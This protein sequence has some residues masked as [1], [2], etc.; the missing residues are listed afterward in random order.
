MNQYTEKEF[1]DN[2]WIEEKREEYDF[3]FEDLLNRY[4]DWDK[5]H[6]YMEIGGAPGSIMLFMNKK[7]ELSVSTIDFTEKNRISRNLDIHGVKDYKIYHEDF[8][9]TDIRAHHG[10]YDIVASWGFLEHFSRKQTSIFIDKQMAMVGE[11]GYFIIELPN[12]R[13]V[14]WLIYW[15]FNRKMIKIHNL[16][17]MDLEWL[18]SQV[19]R[20]HN[21]EILYASY[22]FAL[23]ENNVFFQRHPKL[24]MLCL[25]IV[26]KFKRFRLT[27]SIKR[28]F[29]PYIIIIAKRRLKEVRSCRS[30]R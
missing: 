17:I 28:W 27:D 22:Y 2:Y 3:Y 8:D 1:W 16:K 6:S 18:K 19:I 20:K 14:M 10:K 5:L 21:F 26:K 29:Y 25:R 23:N 13:K 11:E 4:I 24:K 30:R 7:H 12:I 15:I 9:A